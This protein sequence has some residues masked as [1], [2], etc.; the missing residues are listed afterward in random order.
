MAKS[1]EARWVSLKGGG[2]RKWWIRLKAKIDTGAARCSIDQKLAK[3]LG[4]K[5]I[6][7]IQVRNAMGKQTRRLVEAKIRVGRTTYDI[8]VSVTDRTE[9]SCA[10]ILGKDLIDMVNEDSL[11]PTKSGTTVPQFV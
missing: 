7:E 10:M 6:G 5:E 8:E 2:K 1:F 9:L 11:K 3:A 4:L